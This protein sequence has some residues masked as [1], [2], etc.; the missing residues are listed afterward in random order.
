MVNF[1]DNPP[2][3]PQPQNIAEKEN[4]YGIKIY[5]NPSNGLFN[6]ASNNI[7]D[8]DIAVVIF[9]F[10]GTDC[11][12]IRIGVVKTRTLNLSDLSKGIYLIRFSNK[13]ISQ[14]KKLII[15]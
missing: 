9:R 4:E 3:D 7:K 2:P 10:N 11:K 1:F 12:A 13:D 14:V 15:D 6:L 5:P 8:S